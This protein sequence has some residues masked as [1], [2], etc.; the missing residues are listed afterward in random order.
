MSYESEYHYDTASKP[1]QRCSGLAALACFVVVGL[2][3]WVWA[4][5]NG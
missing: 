2:G 4:S 5:I 1:R 3:L